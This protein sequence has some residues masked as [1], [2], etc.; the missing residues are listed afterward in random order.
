MSAPGSRS[1][2]PVAVVGATGL[3]GQRLVSLLDDHPLFD[4]VELAASSRSAGRSYVE[5]APWRLAAPIP[6]RAAGLEV[7]PAHP[8]SITAPLVFSALDPSVARDLEAAFARAGRSVIS[9]ARAFRME[10][11]V[12]LVVPEVN[13]DHLALIDA[14]REQRDWKGLI[15]TNPNCS[16]IGLVL[17]LAPLHAAARIRRVVVTTLQAAS[18][19]GYPGV[20]ALDLIDNVVPEIPGEEDKLENEPKKI[21]GTFDAGVIDEPALAI[22]S[23]THRVPVQDGHLLAVSLETEESLSPDDAAQALDEYRGQIADLDLPSAP[24]RPVAVTREPSRPQPRLD[25][26]AGAGMTVTVGRI[27]PCPVLGLRMLVLSH[28]TLRGAA[29]DTLLLAEL[30][31][32]RGLL[33]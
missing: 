27:R 11:D 10:P 23:H 28:N 19:A 1:K 9:N 30:V 4:L 31:A 14:Q 32:S 33:P 26:D 3:V 25:R 22:A 17:A 8:A 29:T 15:A 2:I 24:E 7:R 20:P 6:E 18:G 16:V 21:L 13:A 12:P 5:A